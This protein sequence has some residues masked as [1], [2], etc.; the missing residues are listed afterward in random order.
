[1]LATGRFL[2]MFLASILRFLDK[3]R[4]IKA[5]PVDLPNIDVQVGI[6]TLKSRTVN[7][8]AKLYI[9][10]AREIARPLEK[11]K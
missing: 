5:L 1:M 9:E 7:P 6:F 10:Q 2:S 8:V 11:R 4:G 3:G